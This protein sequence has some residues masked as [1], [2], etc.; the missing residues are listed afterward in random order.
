VYRVVDLPNVS[1]VI[2]CRNEARFITSCLD[3]FVASDYPQDLIEVEVVDGMSTDATRDILQAWVASGPQRR[4]LDNPKKTAAA[5]MNVG[6]SA[7]TGNV[8]VRLDV[9]ARYP[10][11]YVRSCVKALVETGAEIVGGTVH[12]L[13]DGTGTMAAA[14]AGAVSS[15]FGVGGT[16]FRVGGA[17]TPMQVDIVPFGCFQR[18]LVESV[19]WFDETMLRDEDA[20]FCF[21]VTAQGGRVVLCPGIHSEYVARGR[22]S[23]LWVQY[24]LYGFYKPAIARKVHKIM[25]IRQLVPAVFVSTLLVFGVLS[26]WIEPARWMFAVEAVSYAA[27]V[28]GA[29]VVEAVLRRDWRLILLLL[30]YPVIHVAYGI[31][32]LVGATRPVRET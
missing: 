1:V 20:D 16:A 11:D 13:P 21:R 15:R 23:R 18:S 6:I 3:D 22:L 29:T 30:V 26:V 10:A 28:I 17:E 4:M 27:A 5:A 14:I 24:F 8:I 9:H 2:P 12:T 25:T 7:S 19:G 31:G 32:Y